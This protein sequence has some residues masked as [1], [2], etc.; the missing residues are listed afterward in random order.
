[1]ANMQKSGKDINL[2]TVE[3]IK[4]CMLEAVDRFRNE[5]E[6]RFGDVF[7]LNEVLSSYSSLA[8]KWIRKKTK[9]CN[10]IKT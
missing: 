3:K 5:A 7:L 10:L 9:Q 1:M 6:K 4:R 8:A 2:S